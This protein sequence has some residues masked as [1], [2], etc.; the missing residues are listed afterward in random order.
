MFGF[1]DRGR[2]QRF[3]HTAKPLI[4]IIKKDMKYDH[5][6]EDGFLPTHREGEP[7]W[8]F[9]WV[10]MGIIL[11]FIAWMAVIFIKILHV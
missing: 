3:A 1:K 8:S 6:D 11:F 9:N 5:F 7:L 10:D 4:G 2:N